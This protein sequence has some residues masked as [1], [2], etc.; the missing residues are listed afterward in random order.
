MDDDQR[1]RAARPELV[2]LPPALSVGLVVATIAAIEGLRLAGWPVAAPFALIYTALA[3]AASFSGRRA[4]LLAA[5]LATLYAG[6]SV[7]TGFGPETLTGG[8]LQLAL[9]ATIAFTVCG[10]LGYEHDV[11]AR[12]VRQLRSRE[13]RLLRRQ[14]RLYGSVAETSPRVQVTRGGMTDTRYLLE[15]A[16]ARA[17]IGVVVIDRE[18]RLLLVNPAARLQFGLGPDSTGCH[19]WQDL[20]GAVDFRGADGERLPPTGGPPGDAL[21]AGASCEDYE[22]RIDGAD[23]VSRWFSGY[24][25]PTLTRDGGISGVVVMLVDQTRRMRTTRAL[26]R[27]TR[28]LFRVREEERG[29]LARELHEEIG[30]SLAAIKFALHSDGVEEGRVAGSLAKIDDLTSTI[31]QLSLELRPPALD[32]FGLATAIRA[33]LERL[34]AEHG[35]DCR[36]HSDENLP[37]APGEIATVAYRIVQEAVGNA[38]EHAN[39]AAI[40]VRLGTAGDELLLEIRD[41]GSGFDLEAAELRAAAAGQLGLLFMRERARQY[42]GSLKLETRAGLG[43]TVSA[44]LPLETRTTDAENETG[45]DR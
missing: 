14:R 19:T 27:L 16:L 21:A 25:G 32:D 12:L 41:D 28:L 39:A 35:V 8:P 1:V 31:R 5:L 45:P 36:L 29:M 23:G 42:G 6:W 2:H 17:P 38:L 7:R 44:R 20:L 15:Q 10:V 9:A 4:G 3:F 26:A 33:E 18:W 40:T 22:C 24:V 30:Q 34:G 43:T 37:A 13:R 11:R